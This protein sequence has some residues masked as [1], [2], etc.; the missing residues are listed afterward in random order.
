MD[1]KGVIYKITNPNGKIYI[2]QTTKL[3]KRKGAYKR[4]DS[5]IQNQIVLY[6]SLKKYG[7]DAH[8]FEII[9]NCDYEK[10]NERERYWQDFYNVLGKN[11]L[12]CILT[13]TT[14]LKRVYTTALSI[15]RA[16]AD[17]NLL[18]SYLE[19]WNLYISGK[20]TKYINNLYPDIDDKVIWKIK[21]GTHWFNK[22]LKE[23]YDIHYDDYKHLIPL[24]RFSYKQKA[25]I[26]KLYYE[27][28]YTVKQVS[29]ILNC[30]PITLYKILK[31]NKRKPSKKS[32]VVIQ[33]DLENNFI[34]EWTS[35]KEIENVLKF[36]KNSI[37]AACNGTLKTYKKYKWK[38]KK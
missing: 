2:G 22:Y 1:N 19:I 31:I 18:T 35:A 23:K 24:N 9:E 11:G 28:N 5:C 25:E 32:N 8:T 36:S 12:N 26:L 13:E 21:S 34:K 10:L 16:K 27:E 29:E 3:L 14:E 7:W 4:L 37:N 20:N 33:L 6:R 15:S 17:E 38:Y 30:S